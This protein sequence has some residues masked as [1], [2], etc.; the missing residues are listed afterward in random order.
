MGVAGLGVLA[1]AAGLAAVRAQGPGEGRARFRF[2]GGVPPLLLMRAL[3]ADGDGELSA[4]EIENATA[5]LKTLDK[6]RNGKLT[7]E[8]MYPASERM[9]RLGQGPGAN[10]EQTIRTLLAFDKDGDGKLSKAE[11]PERLKVLMD[12]ADANK[13]GFLDRN[14]LTA[15]ARGRD[16]GGPGAGPGGPEGRGGE[17]PRR[18]DEGSR[19]DQRDGESQRRGGRPREIDE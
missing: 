11:L 13:D 8:E 10:V 15:Y 1:V 14:E 18:K 3:D 19:R 17:G 6:D 16:R 5:A 9:G 7:R 2:E 4:K 12:R